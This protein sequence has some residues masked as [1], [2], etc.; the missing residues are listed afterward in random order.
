M[1]ASMQAGA[2]TYTLT[3]EPNYP[4]AQAQEVYKP[5]LSYLSKST[6]QTFVLK[7]APNYHVHWR[8]MRSKTKVDFTFEEAHFTDYRA[9]RQRMIPLVRVV[10]PTKYTLLISDEMAAGGA[11]GL[12]G[13]RITSMSSPS[14]GYLL[15]G[16]IY[17]NPIAQ[18]EIKSFAANLKDGVEMIFA[19]E[20]DGAMVP[21]YIA[22]QYS[23][24]QPAMVTRE[25]PGRALSAHETVPVEVRNAV[26]NAMLKLHLDNN[27]YD[28]ISELGTAKFVPTNAATYA[29]S[30]SI[31][32][33]AYGYAPPSYEKAA[34]AAPAAAPAP[35]K[36]P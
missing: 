13:H 8:D 29:G 20:S 4:P 1:F 16:E 18:P 6:G 14:L 17:R 30:E 25:L 35:A 19:G 2:A 36:K 21:S 5:L 32:S 28:V 7:I 11:Q 22:D 12:I 31:L 9:K 23:N 24:L 3:V 34:N 10:E 27:L 26:K 33:A 15:L